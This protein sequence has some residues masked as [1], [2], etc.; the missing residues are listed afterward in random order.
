ML[1]ASLK[2][3]VKFIEPLQIQGEI[4]GGQKQVKPAED[5]ASPVLWTWAYA[6]ELLSFWQGRGER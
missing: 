3:P 1:E 4:A 6:D 2:F 5:S